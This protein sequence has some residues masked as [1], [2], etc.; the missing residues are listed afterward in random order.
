M[1]VSMVLGLKP[2]EAFI[3]HIVPFSR[4]HLHVFFEVLQFHEFLSAC[5]AP[6]YDLTRVTVRVS[7]KVRAATEGFITVRTLE[8]TFSRMHD[9]V[10]I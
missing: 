4:M 10:V 3:A 1:S 8:V 9:H 7:F 6:M 2:F 5:L